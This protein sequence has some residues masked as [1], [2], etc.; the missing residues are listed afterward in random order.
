[1][2]YRRARPQGF[3]ALEGRLTRGWSV[4]VQL[5]AASRLVTD[6]DSYPGGMAYLRVGSKFGL[7]PGWMLEA[8][9]TEGVKNQIAIT[10]FGV[11]VAVGRRF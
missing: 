2:V 5:D 9:I 6:I 8:G 3:L 4:I 11:L 7:R 1:M 10:D